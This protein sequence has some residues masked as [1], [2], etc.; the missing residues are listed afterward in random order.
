MSRQTAE[1]REACAGFFY[2]APPEDLRREL[3][4]CFTIAAANAPNSA[5]PD[6]PPLVLIVPHAGYS[7]SGPV[8][9]CAYQRLLNVQDVLVVLLGPSHHVYINGIAG[10]SYTGWRT[11]L[12]TIQSISELPPALREFVRKQGNAYPDAHIPEHSLEVQLPFLQTVLAPGFSILPLLVGR[13]SGAELDALAEALAEVA[14]GANG[15]QVIFVCSTDLSHD[16]LYAEASEMDG[17]LARLVERLDADAFIQAAESR[18][19]EACGMYALGLC[20][21]LARAMGRTSAEI[22]ALT[23]S[24]EIIGDMRSRIVGYMAACVA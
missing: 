22:L 7:Y 18:Q 15:K 23:N 20:M 21:R 3:A 8:A 13:L 16:H 17:R 2:P 11:P 1:R 19:I 12:G 5:V 9:A 4:R 24:G 6:A 14:R 10:A